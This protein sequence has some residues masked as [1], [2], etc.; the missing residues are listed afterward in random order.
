MAHLAPATFW[1]ALYSRFYKQRKH[2]VGGQ[3]VHLEQRYKLIFNTNQARCIGLTLNMFYPV[4]LIDQNRQQAVLPFD[5]QQWRIRCQWLR[6]Q[7]KALTQIKDQC[8]PG[9]N[10]NCSQ[11]FRWAV[12]QR[13]DADDAN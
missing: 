13:R 7:A 10:I 4:Y 9:M 8:W 12:G 5:E 11:H 2:S 1:Q 3:L 6:R